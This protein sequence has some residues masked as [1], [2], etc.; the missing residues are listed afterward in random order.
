M[1]HRK[2]RRTRTSP[3]SLY[4]SQLPLDRRRMHAYGS[5]QFAKYE[6]MVLARVEE[7]NTCLGACTYGCMQKTYIYRYDEYMQPLAPPLPAC[8]CE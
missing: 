4:T 3:V 5:C 7:P 2:R 8:P 6:Y 1:S